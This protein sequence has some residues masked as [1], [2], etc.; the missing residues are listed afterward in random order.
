MSEEG[1]GNSLTTPSKEANN[2]GAQSNA[3]LLNQPPQSRK[4]MGGRSPGMQDQS[5]S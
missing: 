5:S 3:N 1:L 2:S 4:R